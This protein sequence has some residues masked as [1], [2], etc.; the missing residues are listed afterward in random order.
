MCENLYEQLRPLEEINTCEIRSLSEREQL[1]YST[2][3]QRNMFFNKYKDFYY[4]AEHFCL[5]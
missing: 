1:A 3:L 4:V 5:S 2:V